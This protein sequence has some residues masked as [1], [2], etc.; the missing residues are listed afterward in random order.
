[1]L[2]GEIFDI[3]SEYFLYISY[4]SLATAV[5]SKCISLPSKA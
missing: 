1:M 4:E 3:D 2:I 5:W